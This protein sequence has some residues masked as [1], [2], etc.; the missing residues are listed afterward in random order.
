MPVPPNHPEV[1]HYVY[2]MTNRWNTVLYIGSTNNL[3]RR[4]WEHRTGLRQNAFTWQY[5][6]NKLVWFE[7]LPDRATALQR[8]YRMNQWKRAWKERL[9]NELNPTWPDI[10]PPYE[11]D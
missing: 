7:E 1:T 3:A 4:A 2:R 10:A 9:V 5:Q 6:C 11:H 8:E